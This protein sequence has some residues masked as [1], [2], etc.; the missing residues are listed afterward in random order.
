MSSFWVE[1]GVLQTGTYSQVKFSKHQ[2]S[3][4]PFIYRIVEY[5]N[6]MVWLGKNLKDHLVPTIVLWAETKARP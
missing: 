5:Y 2:C 4:F 1:C 3:F 6:R